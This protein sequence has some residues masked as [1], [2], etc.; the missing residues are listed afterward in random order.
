[1]PGTSRCSTYNTQAKPASIKA[2][3]FLQSIG[4]A[5]HYYEKERALDKY[6]PPWILVERL[7][8]SGGTCQMLPQNVSEYA[9]DFTEAHI[10]K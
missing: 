7:Q 4:P 1:M 9:P 2:V 8:H 10:R 5:S 6:C 3:P